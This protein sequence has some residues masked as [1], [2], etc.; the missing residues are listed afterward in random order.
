MTPFAAVVGAGDIGGATAQA[1]AALDCVREV[2]LIDTSPG[3]AAGK[4]LDVAQAAACE[5]HATRL[6]GSED[7][8]SA[9][10]AAAIVIADRFGAASR[11][12]QGEEGLALIRRVWDF[13]QP[14]GSIVVCAGI[15]GANLVRVA[16]GELH[17]DRRCIIG[18]APAAFEA[19]ARA[20]V[21]I[22]LDGDGSAVGLMVLGDVPAAAVPCW[23]QATVAGAALTSRLSAAQ[24][25][26]LESR[27]PKLWPPGPY[28]LGSAASH[29]VRAI[30]GGSRSELTTAVA[31]DGEMGMRHV[32]AALPVRLGPRGVERIVEPVLTP[33]ER[34]RLARGFRV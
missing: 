1:I 8:R 20:L 26:A 7:V 11:E 24:L 13:A 3:V 18:T 14:D 31:L 34:V 9:A 32:V 2:R 21:A 23:S 10:G 33:Q 6:V 28:A 17:V 25:Q 5:G 19:G 27:L 16:V 12:W 29:A 30:A 4:A 15:E 22:A